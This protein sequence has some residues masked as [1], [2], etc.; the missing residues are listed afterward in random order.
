MKILKIDSGKGYYQTKEG[1]EKTMD[2]LSKEELIYLVETTINN[3]KAEID[4]FKEELLTN[5]AHKI[6]YQNVYS[7]LDEIKKNREVI[8]ANKTVLYKQAIEK[9]KN[10]NEKV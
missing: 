1:V 9:Y 10:N 3:E 8:V 7:K 2:L 5:P 6:I 4:E